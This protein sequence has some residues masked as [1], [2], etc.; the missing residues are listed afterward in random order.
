MGVQCLAKIPVE[1]DINKVVFIG[2]MRTLQNQDAVKYFITDIFPIIK[3]A[4]PKAI[5]Y[6]IGAEP[7]TAVQN[8]ADGKNIIVSGFVPSVEDEIKN[9][10]VAVAS[11]RIAAGIQNKVLVSMACGVPVVLTS[12]ISVGIPE[13][14]NNENSIISDKK[15]DFAQAVIS[16]MKNEYLRNR[17]GK[18]GYDMVSTKYSWDKMLYGYEEGVN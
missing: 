4:L 16:L 18:A 7:P 3:G 12:L 1:Y 15:T 11:V 9:A 8:L 5:F 17:I 2:N 6:V 10:A 13:L 14:V